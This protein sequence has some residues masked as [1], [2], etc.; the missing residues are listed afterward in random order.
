[1]YLFKYINRYMY[2]CID[3]CIFLRISLEP[4]NFDESSDNNSDDSKQP[5]DE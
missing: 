3:Q 5:D 1:M 4:T 2:G